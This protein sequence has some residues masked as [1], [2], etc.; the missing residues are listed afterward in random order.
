MEMAMIKNNYRWVMVAAGGLLGC[1]VMG[2]MFSLPVFI[3]PIAA[4]TG[5]S[6]TGV[7]SAMTVGFLSMAFAA[8]S[9]GSLSDR[10]GPFAV[11]LTGSILLPV[12]LLIVSQ[13]TSRFAYQLLFGVL[14]GGSCA[15]IL[16]PMMA[17]VTGWFDTHRSL[18]VSLVSAGIGVAP[19]TMAPLAARLITRYHR[20]TSWHIIPPLPA[21]PFYPPPVPFS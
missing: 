15:A 5:W 18:A 11:V 13:T 10:V 2:S 21:F 6:V 4:D 7:S 19:L 9:W 1:I 20:R 14:V 17:S 8:M 3:R 16:A 12:S